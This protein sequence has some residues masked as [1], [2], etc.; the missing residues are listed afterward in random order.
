MSSKLQLE[1]ATIIIFHIIT[2][3]VSIIAVVTLYIK[4]NKTPSLKAFIYVQSTMIVWMVF[5]VFKTVAP[6]IEIRWWCIVSYYGAICLLEVAFLE[7][8]YVYYK[9]IALSKK[10]KLL[11]YIVPVIQFI[12]I[13][14]NPYHHLF[15]SHY[16]FYSDSFG[17]LFYVHL[18]IEYLY[19]LIGSIF[20]SFKFKKL[21]KHT[22][23]VYRYLVVVAILTPVIFNLIYISG[24]FK[25]I[26]YAMKL[27][28]IFD[29]TPIAFTISLLIFVYVTFKYEFFNLSP[30][31]EHEI[32]YELN[33]PICV[34]NEGYDV[35]FVNDKFK[36]IFY[37]DYKS[38]INMIINNNKSMLN[39]KEFEV[40]KEIWYGDRC[41]LIFRKTISKGNEIQYLITFD[42]ITAYKQVEYQTMK[43]K[44][45]FDQANIKLNE[46]IH[47]LKETSKVGARS[48]VARE[49]H[50]IIGHSLVV[51]TKLLEVA[52]LYY[53]KDKNMSITALNDA[54]LSIETGISG[55]QDISRKTE[56]DSTYTG[57]FLKKEL[58]KML[59]HVRKTGVNTNLVF[60]GTLYIIDEKLFDVIK[61]V[62]TELVTNS[63]K[64]AKAN[65]ILLSINITTL[66]INILVIDN[67]IG[68]DK[69]IQGNGLSGID[70][71][72][73]IVEGKAQYNSSIG[74][75]FSTN[76]Y[77]PQAK[78]C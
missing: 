8:G 52:R 44:N 13:L 3:S 77:I 57:S 27:T 74:E 49:L 4:S 62:C 25:G 64:H 17:N 11:V 47:I 55:M 61:K 26:I 12:C 28:V 78:G 73:K 5:K 36:K 60:K 76:I 42:E 30:I 1:I 16:D 66:S 31:M 67:G 38:E 15:Y 37:T 29:I 35:L 51:T 21:L 56:I 41:F 2:I 63:L 71:R 69:I 20:C 10:I 7:F 50:D 34:L 68:C 32:I 45:D 43:K 24:A 22:G 48:Y 54:V 58:L 39:S 23:I 70:N 6:T 46:T 65:N 75:G 18:I 59:K 72:L 19:I 33:T 40:K 9:G 14:T 53:K